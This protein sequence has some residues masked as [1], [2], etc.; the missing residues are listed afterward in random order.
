ML[1]VM[2]G[3]PGSGK[4]TIAEAA[5]RML[6][7]AVVAVDPIE[8]AMRTAGIAHD[9]PTGLAAYVAAEAVARAQL[10]LG[11]VVIVD[12]VNDAEPARAQWRDL[13]ASEGA[14]LEFVEVVLTDADA[15]R[16]RLETR[17]RDLGAFP[18]PT[19]AS[20]DARRS[21]FDGWIDDRLRLDAT[22]R[23]A[24]NA[25]LIAALVSDRG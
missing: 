22:R 18:E 23:I 8:A 17:D 19:W 12:A 4:S 3:L 7:C 2:A 9:Q 6:S 15:H 11:H 14:R 25:A 16:C 21:G 24:E 13:A 10:R 5:A 1:I 20:V